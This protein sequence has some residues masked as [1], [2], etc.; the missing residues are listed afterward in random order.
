MYSGKEKRA[1]ISET[2]TLLVTIIVFNALSEVKIY[3]WYEKQC[4]TN[5]VLLVFL[6]LNIINIKSREI[7]VINF[8]DKNNVRKLILFEK[9][10]SHVEWGK[11]A[12]T[13]WPSFSAAAVQ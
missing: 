9:I 7:T 13:F 6:L 10:K 4:R 8:C 12:L 3:T 2:S 5:I 11:P 1:D